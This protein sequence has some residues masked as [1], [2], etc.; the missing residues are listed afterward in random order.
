[1]VDVD[2]SSLQV[3]SRPSWLTCQ[4]LG[5]VCIHQIN[6]GC[7]QQQPAGELTAQ[8]VDLS[9]T[10]CC[11]HSSNKPSQL[12]QLL[13][14]DDSNKHC[15]YIAGSFRSIL[16]VCRLKSFISLVVLL[17]VEFKVCDLYLYVFVVIF[18]VGL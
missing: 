12:L 1:M 7:G 3:N 9:A 5:A 17:A 4:P 16:A 10:W 2:S 8:L 15:P 14:V 13:N 11:L 6:R 18:L